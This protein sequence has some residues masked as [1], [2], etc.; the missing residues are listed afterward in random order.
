MHIM[1]A[2]GWKLLQ[3][4]CVNYTVERVTWD[5]KERKYVSDDNGQPKITGVTA[6]L[7]TAI[8]ERKGYEGKF[9]SKPICELHN[10]MKELMKFFDDGV[11]MV[12]GKPDKTVE[13]DNDIPE[14]PT[15]FWREWQAKQGVPVPVRSL[16]YLRNR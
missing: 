13:V 14:H 5:A 16:A 11:R 4:T 12:Y 10:S 9:P 8:A 3:P 6:G 7:P 2:D 1:T 15:S